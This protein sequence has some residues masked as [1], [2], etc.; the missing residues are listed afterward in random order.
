MRPRDLL[1]GPWGSMGE[2]AGGKGS[3][4]VKGGIKGIPWG[5]QVGLIS[6]LMIHDAYVPV[7]KLSR[8]FLQTD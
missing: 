6:L 7:Y 3:Q 2:G 8:F 5:P 1:R 4:G